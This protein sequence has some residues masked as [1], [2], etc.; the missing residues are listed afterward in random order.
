MGG[1]LLRTVGKGL[2]RFAPDWGLRSP[3]SSTGSL[4]PNLLLHK[5]IVLRPSKKD[6]LSYHLLGHSLT[7]DRESFW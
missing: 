4:T 2:A 5:R 3:G 7:Y 1:G 6:L